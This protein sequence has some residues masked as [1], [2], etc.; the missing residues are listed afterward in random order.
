VII[1]AQKTDQL[2]TE[3]LRRLAGVNHMTEHRIERVTQEE[4]ATEEW[5]VSAGALTYKGWVYVPKGL[6]SKVTA[7][8]HD[9]T[10]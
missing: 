10:E 2:A 5:T 1:E 6:R 8:N 3:S 7:L 4:T 9:N